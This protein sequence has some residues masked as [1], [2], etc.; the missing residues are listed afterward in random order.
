M[1]FLN[2]LK[3]YL[4]GVGLG[5]LLVMAIFKDRKLTSWTP[6]NQVMKEIK[7]KELLLS[8][9]KKE[10]FKC[11]GLTS[12]KEIKDF[13]ISANI[14]FGKSEVENHDERLYRLSFKDNVITNVVVLIKEESVEIASIQNEKSS[15]S[16]L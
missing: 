6:H 3:Y 11:L 15:C 4:F 2:R 7:E 1:N 12:E 13:L 10:C 8:I 14:N 9:E 16:C 5:I